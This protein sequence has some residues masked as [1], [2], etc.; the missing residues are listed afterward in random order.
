MKRSDNSKA[1]GAPE[2]YAGAIG[3]GLVLI[4]KRGKS[5]ATSVPKE[6]ADLET[7]SLSSNPGLYTD[8]QIDGWMKEDMLSASERKTIVKKAGKK[9]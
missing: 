8:K 1:K 9:W 6:N 7:D 5:V 3:Q 4:T 2:E